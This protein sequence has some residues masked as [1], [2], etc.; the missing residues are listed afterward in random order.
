M[1]ALTRLPAALATV[2][3]LLLL[4]IAGCGDDSDGDDGR[5]RLD[6]G[7]TFGLDSASTADKIAFERAEEE[8]GIEIAITETG[9]PTATVA[10]LERGDLDLGQFLIRSVIDANRQGAHLHAVIGSQMVPDYLLVAGSGIDDLADLGGA[11]LAHHGPGTD[12]EALSGLA[13]EQAGLSEDEVELTVLPESPNRATALA[14]GRI[15]AAVLE[16]VDVQRLRGQGF[17]LNVLAEMRDFW[18]GSASGGWAVSD[19]TIEEDPELVADVIRVMLDTYESLYTG[20]GREQWLE[21][22]GAEALSGESEETREAL[23]DHLLEIGMWPRRAEPVTEESY[24]AAVRFWLQN[25]LIEEGL[26]F[27]RVWDVSFWQRAAD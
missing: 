25:G 4:G 17:R 14:N 1:R 19:E 26:P 8:L 20:E 23:L 2:L 7:L 11:R 24:D 21:E 5:Q 6:A 27:A 22:T 9:D 3:A 12:T 10:G 13:L 15:D 16:S 18:P